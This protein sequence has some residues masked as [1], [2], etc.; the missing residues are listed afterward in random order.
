MMLEELVI[1]AA[2]NIVAIVLAR[3]VLML[4]EIAL[5]VSLGVAV[6]AFVTLLLVELLIVCV[7]GR[8]MRQ[9]LGTRQLLALL[10]RKGAEQW[11]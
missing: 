2:S 1:L 7:Y 4:P 11:R 6:G 3:Y 5:P 10:A 9:R 8:K